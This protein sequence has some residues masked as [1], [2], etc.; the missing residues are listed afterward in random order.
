MIVLLVIAVLILAIVGLILRAVGTRINGSGPVDPSSS[1][2]AR[3]WDELKERQ[4]A[5][6]HFWSGFFR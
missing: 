3:E 6:A 5:S 4:D 2:A 1:D